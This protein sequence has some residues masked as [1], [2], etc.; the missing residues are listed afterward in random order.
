MHR[1][2]Y[3]Y[4]RAEVSFANLRVRDEARALVEQGGSVTRSGCRVQWQKSY[5]QPWTPYARRGKGGAGG[6]AFLGAQAFQSAG[7]GGTTALI[8]SASNGDGDRDAHT[9][10]DHPGG[11]RHA[12]RNG[13]GPIPP[14]ESARIGG[15]VGPSAPGRVPLLYD[16]LGVWIR[17]TLTRTC[18]TP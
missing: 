5:K 18:A 3:E 15:T 2:I 1:A 14:L 16:G 11:K 7:G 8:P 4:V 12:R 10:Q 13:G 6:R 9:A 17:T